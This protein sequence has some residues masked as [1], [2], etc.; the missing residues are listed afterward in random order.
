MQYIIS[1]REK[2]MQGNLPFQLWRLA[3]LSIRFT[4]LTR[5]GRNPHPAAPPPRRT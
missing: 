4:K 3:R 1:K 2:R 5:L